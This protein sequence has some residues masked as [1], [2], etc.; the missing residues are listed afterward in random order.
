MKIISIV[1][2]EGEPI[3]I[4]SYTEKAFL[5][6]CNDN[7]HANYTLEEL[8]IAELAFLEKYKHLEIHENKLINEYIK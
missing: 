8:N 6:R 7:L 4:R 2:I 3:V 1:N 5:D